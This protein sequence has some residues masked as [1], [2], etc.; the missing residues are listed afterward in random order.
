MKYYAALLLL[1]VGMYLIPLGFRPMITPDEFRYAEIPREM[2]ESGNWVVPRLA[3]MDYFEKPALGYQLTALSF[4]VFG[5]NR[6]ALRFPP[7][8]AAGLTALLLTLFLRR[9][10]RNDRIAALGGVMYLDYGLVFGV[11]TCAVLDAQVT[12]FMAG[13]L[14]TFLPAALAE[15][16]DLPKIVLLLV[17]GIFAG[18]AFLT[19]GF[20]ALAVPGIV[21]VPFL[22]WEKRWKAF[23]TLPWLPL[24][25]FLAVSAPWCIAI[26]KQAPDFWRYFVVVEHWA[27]F[28]GTGF[29]QHNSPWWLY[30]A[31]L[32]PLLLPGGL[33]LPCAIRGL[34]GQWGALL[35]QSYVRYLVCI[36]VV[37]FIFFSACS[38][39]LATYILPCLIPVAALE[40]IGIAEYFRLGGKYRSFRWIMVFCGIVF[41]IA[42]VGGLAAGWLPYPE[43]VRQALPFPAEILRRFMPAGAAALIFGAVLLYQRKKLWRRNLIAFFAGQVLVTGCTLWGIAP[44]LFGDKTQE[45]ALKELEKHLPADVEKIMV[46]R[47]CMH[48]A[49][50]VWNRPHDDLTLVW[51]M[52]EWD[53]PINHGF[54]HRYMSPEQ[55]VKYLH[56]KDRPRCAILFPENTFRKHRK[57][58][59]DDGESFRSNQLLLVV[60]PPAAKNP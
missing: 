12:F 18:L 57:H 50:W 59:P 11:G 24:A 40:A 3:G 30:L 19:K 17:S 33:L 14:L 35:R 7:A 27:R 2:V 9:Y 51:T 45:T 55:L 32:I 54:A 48:G 20:I 5:Y 10:T 36:F 28:T 22:I 23:L 41:V 42:G 26:H 1:F 34:R 44:E 15:K 49:A 46:F 37:P 43:A 52:G 38:G 8:L 16:W 60:Y 13:C 25:A 29:G 47:R 39:K 4:K 6:F 56:A 31:L 21:I 53:Y 58:F